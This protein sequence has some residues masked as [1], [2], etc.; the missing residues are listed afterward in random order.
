MSPPETVRVD[1][2]RS[3]SSRRCG[4]RQAQSSAFFNEYFIAESLVDPGL[5]TSKN[6]FNQ[7]R[8]GLL[9]AAISHLLPFDE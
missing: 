4:R 8:L 7:G 5:P 3:S 1:S 9:D 6:R 2:I